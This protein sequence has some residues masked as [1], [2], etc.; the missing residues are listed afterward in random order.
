MKDLKKKTIKGL[1]WSLANK[2]ITQGLVLLILVILS[3]LLTPQDFGL[4]TM[5][6]VL[7][8]FAQIFQ[9]FG[10][11]S[12]LI[13]KKEISDRDLNT[14]FWF[15]MCM[16][17][18]LTLIILFS[19]PLIVDFYDKP[20][21]YWISV[22]ASFNFFIRSLNIVQNSILRKEMDFKRLF[23]INL[24]ANAIAGITAIV[25][26]YMGYGVWSLVMQALVLSFMITALLWYSSNWRPKVDFSKDSLKYL[27]SFSIPLLGT[28]SIHYWVRNLDKILIGKFI[29]DA[30]LGFYE[31]SYSIMLLPLSNITGVISNVMFP[32]LSK[33]QDQKEKV[34]QIFLR[35]TRV[36]AFITF[37]A[38]VG[39]SILAEPFIISVLGE[40]WRGSIDILKILAVVGMIQSVTSLFGNLYLS[41]GA[42]GKQ[43]KVGVFLR[44]NTIIWIIVGIKWG[45]IGVS[46]CYLI[47]VLINFFPNLYVAG[48]L[49]KLSISEYLQNIFRVFLLVIPMAVLVWFTETYLLHSYPYVLRLVVG[50]LLG[51]GF[52]LSVAHAIKLREYIDLK[53]V[54]LNSVLKTKNA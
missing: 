43:F 29:G 35:M 12:A 2:V 19:A 14:V 48:G 28:Q 39:L 49:V 25:M 7:I 38:M 51:A 23:F 42:T 10:L 5:V 46:I 30:Q 8:R 44:I 21:L 13:Q 26:A 17:L 47:A 41:Q 15:N 32:S 18:A 50:T 4:I 16:G 6:M 34:K 33:I 3:R 40:Q 53:T 11:G 31:K 36:I 52:Y 24:I 54:L 20:I 37:P 45:I 1:K 9:D 27:F 22:F